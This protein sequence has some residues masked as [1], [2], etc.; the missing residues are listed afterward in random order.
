[1]IAFVAIVII[2]GVLKSCVLFQPMECKLVDQ[3]NENEQ[4]LQR[5]DKAPAFSMSDLSGEEVSVYDIF[6][7]HERVLVSFWGSW[8]GPCLGKLHGLKRIYEK[9]SDDGF[10]IVSVALEK[11]FESWSD[12]SERFDIPWKN[13]GTLEYWSSD[14]RT[15][16]GVKFVPSHFLVDSNGCVRRTNI[17]LDQLENL[18]TTTYGWQE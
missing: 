11:S 8:C 2:V 7:N 10:E 1:M 17:P 14:V 5:G 16:Y 4:L 18:L 15:A 9:F 3:S 13:L 12:I 6:S